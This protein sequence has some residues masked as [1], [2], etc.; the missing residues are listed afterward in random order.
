M[1]GYVM[2]AFYVGVIPGDVIAVVL[3]PDLNN[4]PT[5][6]R[7]LTTAEARMLAAALMNCADEI[8]PPS[9]HEPDR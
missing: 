9:N 4:P 6:D 1:S 8:D 2:P 7:W 3:T 5:H